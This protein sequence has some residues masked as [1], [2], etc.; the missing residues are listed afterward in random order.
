LHGPFAE[1]VA[2]G[3]VRISWETDEPMTSELEFGMGL[4]GSR[5]LNEPTLKQQHEFTLE[6]V[7]HDVVYRYRVGGQTED[8]RRVMTE[9]YLFD[10]H[11]EY[12]PVATPDRPSPY[13]DDEAAEQDESLARRML[14][15]AGV[16]RGYALVLGADQGRL[17]YFLA[18]NSDL[19][20]VVVEPDEE[21][22]R[23]VRAA[24]DA[25]GLQGARVTVLQGE[26]DEPRFGPYVFNLITSER[27]LRGDEIPGKA[28]AVYRG[29]RPQGGT[30][31]WASVGGPDIAARVASWAAP[32]PELSPWSSAA[33]DSGALHYHKRGKLP[34]SG[35]WRH[36]YAGPD[37]AACSRDDRLRGQLAVQWWGRPGARPMPDRGNRN[38]PPVSANGRLY[39]QGN[40][41][42]FGLDAYNGTI[43]WSLQIP[44]MRRANMPRDGSNMVADDDHLWVAIGGRCVG[45]DG[46]TGRRVLQRDVP[47]LAAQQVHDWGYVSRVGP[48]LFGSGVRPGSQ[49]DG[50]R[51]EWYESFGDRDVARVNSDYLFAMYGDTGQLRWAYQQGIIMNSTITIGDDRVYFIESRNAAAKQAESGRLL[52]EI[53][54]DQFLVALD[55][56][57]GLVAWQKPFD[58]SLCESV[59]YVTHA[60]GVLLVSGTDKQAR[61]HTY[62]FDAATGEEL[63][64]YEMPDQKGHHTGHLA[65]P[66][67]VGDRVYFN[68]HTF[69]LRT[70]EVLATE[71]F[72]WHGCGIMSASNHLIFSRY[73]YHGIFD[74][75]SGQRTELLGLRSGCWLSLIPSGGLL[76]AP[77]TSAGCSCGH[78]LQTSVAYVPAAD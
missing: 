61:F 50:D 33:G 44:T 10:A 62:A 26:L 54:H 76:L 17:A 55:R 75:V 74:P 41:T 23:R 5:T 14:E 18:R 28:A 66:T 1:F 2:S 34:G 45:F 49:Y 40:R 73:E 7:Q 38:P 30:L 60:N 35:E 13:A 19:Q 6:A 67:I 57:T 69:D 24:M 47:E 16:R 64:Q 8:G 25:A 58:F 31:V 56:E 42:L 27:V 43:L 53:L 22:V 3:T 37:N 63:C 39:V 11:F 48:L 77:E 52:D 36:Q 20:I 68:K 70:G 21:R 59:T 71:D 78:A 32:T 72:N 51:G 65:H 15:L 46:Q 9:P 29:L 12:L 4:S